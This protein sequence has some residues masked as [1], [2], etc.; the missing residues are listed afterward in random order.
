M[1][2]DQK[3]RDELRE[4][5]ARYPDALYG[6][7]G[8]HPR[9]GAGISLPL[10]VL[11]LTGVWI[12]FPGFFSGARGGPPG[13]GPAVVEQAKGALAY[14]LGIDPVDHD[15]VNPSI[16]H[17]GGPTG[18]NTDG[19]EPSETVYSYGNSSLRLGIRA[20]SPKTGLSL[21]TTA[22]GRSLRSLMSI[23]V[24]CSIAWRY[25]ARRATM[26]QLEYWTGRLVGFLVIVLMFYSLYKFLPVRRVRNMTALVAALFAGTLLE[27]AKNVFTGAATQF[28]PSSLYTG[29]I[30]AITWRASGNAGPRPCPWSPAT[31]RPSSG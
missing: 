27:L 22:G 30:A 17:W 26:G 9:A 24:A 6:A 2:L 29:T 15:Q 8:D 1:S 5:A 4:I 3:T 21:G 14:Q 7:P 13:T 11:S 20:L 16:P 23:V 31:A 10:A 18:L 28:S 25:P 19:T 12:S